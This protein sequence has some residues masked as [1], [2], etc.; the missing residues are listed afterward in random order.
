VLQDEN[1]YSTFLGCCDSPAI[2]GGHIATIAITPRT[3]QPIQ[4]ATP[5]NEYSIL[6]T[7]EQMFGVGLLGHTSDVIHVAPLTELLP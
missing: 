6:S 4:T 1:D 7:V 3:T 5:F 2:G